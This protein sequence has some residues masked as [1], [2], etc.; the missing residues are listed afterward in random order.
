MK[1]ILTLV[2]LISS[3]SIVAAQDSATATLIGIQ[4]VDGAT[5]FVEPSTT[6]VVDLTIEKEQI[7]PGPYA[8]YAQKLLGTRGNLVERTSYDVTAATISL[9]DCKTLSTNELAQDK[10][11]IASHL[12]TIDEFAKI[13]PNRLDN[14]IVSAEEAAE[15]TVQAI[16]NIRKH[17]MELITGEAGENVF[18]AGL[19]DALQALDATEQSYLELFYGKK[20][21]TTTHHRY[22]IPVEGDKTSYNIV[23]FSNVSGIEEGDSSDGSPVVLKITPSANTALKYSSEADARAKSTAEVR[24]ANMA[25]CE[26]VYDDAAIATVTLPIYEFG[27]TVKVAK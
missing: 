25:K 5:T 24:I 19:K 18:G 7:I 16:F 2:A 23:K 11:E 26:V 3:I 20:I 9:A 12:G 14:S 27:K 15:Q 21:T 6:I 1:K 8:R 17:R 10:V 4:S 13:L 22:I